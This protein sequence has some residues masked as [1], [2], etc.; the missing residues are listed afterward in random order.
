[1]TSLTSPH[2]C[3]M[4]RKIPTAR[5]II[6]TSIVPF[7]FLKLYSISVVTTGWLEY[8]RPHQKPYS[9]MQGTRKM[10]LVQVL[11]DRASYSLLG[12]THKDSSHMRTKYTLYF[13]QTFQWV[14]CNVW[15]ADQSCWKCKFWTNN[16]VYF[17]DVTVTVML[18][19]S[20]NKQGTITTQHTASYHCQIF[21]VKQS[22]VEW[23]S[24][25][26]NNWSSAYWYTEREVCF[27]CH[28]MKTN[29]TPPK[30]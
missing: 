11:F 12:G 26:Q 15:A 3:T 9:A 14:S 10:N 16:Q 5:H 28:M 21:T 1:M 17:S 30:M 6:S 25:P 20:Q 7:P 27:V 19:S 22:M 18:S 4:V 2:C 13:L 24:S 8:M 23:N 29:S